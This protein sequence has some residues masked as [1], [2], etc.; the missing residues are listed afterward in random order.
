LYIGDRE[1]RETDEKKAQIHTLEGFTSAFIIVFAL[2]FAVQAI[3]ITPTS[4]STASQ[5]VE[6]HNYKMVDDVLSQSKAKGELKA[7]MLYW[8]ETKGQFGESIEDRE[9]YSGR[10]GN[11]IPDVG[12]D[13]P[14]PKSFN[15]TLQT[16]HKRGI[17][18]N[19]HLMCGGQRNRFVYNGQ[20]SKHA[21]TAS[22]TVQLYDQDKV[23]VTE[24]GKKNLSEVDYICDDVSEDT[25]LHSVVEVRITAWRM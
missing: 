24:G 6:L 20:P 13:E 22:V 3:G 5:A 19:I 14:S 16:L 18:H 12:G 10:L 11:T 2:L 21:V 1:Q 25:D 4:S 9:H 23:N 17:A 15:D 7:S 8:N